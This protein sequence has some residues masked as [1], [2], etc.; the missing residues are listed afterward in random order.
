MYHC[1]K[2]VLICKKNNNK[3]QALHPIIQA[4]LD[5]SY[6]NFTLKTA[7]TILN[8][9]YTIFGHEPLSQIIGSK[10]FDSWLILGNYR[11]MNFNGNEGS[12]NHQ[13]VERLT[14]KEVAK[15]VTVREIWQHID[16]IGMIWQENRLLTLSIKKLSLDLLK[17][18]WQIKYKFSFSESK[19]IFQKFPPKKAE[20][21]HSSDSMEGSRKHNS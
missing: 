8:K 21:L 9:F 18:Y 14:I 1:L 10:N 12:N 7:L 13:V 20:I 3:S 11:S 6:A 4:N 5:Y 15:L 2:I 16:N 17:D 19:R